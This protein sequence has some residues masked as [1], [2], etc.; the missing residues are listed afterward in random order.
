MR[1]LTLLTAIILLLSATSCSL[2]KLVNK[3][4]SKSFAKAPYDVVIIPGYP[5]EASSHQELFSIRVHWAKALYDRGIARNF[6]FSGNA[7][8]TPYVEGTLMKIFA[9][10]L[11]IPSGNTFIEPKA[12]HSNEN[13]IYGKKLAKKLGFKK[14]AVASDPYQVA[15]LTILVDLYTPGMPIL[16]FSPDSMPFFN[17]DLP[18][19]NK[20]PAYVQNWVSDL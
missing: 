15:Y 19:I 14:I 8:H 6:I 16:T 13:L 18:A 3:K 20:N 17:K 5:F 7:V 2:E 9:D 1:Y 11:G 10:S 12:L 4:N